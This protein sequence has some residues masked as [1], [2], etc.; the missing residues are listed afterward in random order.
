VKMRARALGLL[1]HADT[2]HAVLRS[3]EYSLAKNV[4]PSTE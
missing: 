4:L 3:L 2:E 1:Y